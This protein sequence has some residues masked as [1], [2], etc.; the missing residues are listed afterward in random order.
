MLEAS[1]RNRGT[2]I[3]FV[4]FAAGVT[5][6]VLDANGP[7]GI[8]LFGV[9]AAAVVYLNLVPF[10]GAVRRLA[11]TRPKSMRRRSVVRVVRGRTVAVVTAAAAVLFA[12]WLAVDMSR[13]LVYATWWGFCVLAAWLVGVGVL[14]ARRSLRTTA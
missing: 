11:A 2:V 3:A 1:K 9:A 6:T 5:G 10:R 14:T 8:A 13:P 4:L 12:V 7:I